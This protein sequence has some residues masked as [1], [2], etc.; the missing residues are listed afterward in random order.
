MDRDYGTHIILGSPGGLG[1]WLESYVRAQ[2]GGDSVPTPLVGTASY[3]AFELLRASTFSRYATRALA[4]PSK[5]RLTRC[6]V[7]GLT[8]SCLAI[9]RTPGL[10]GI[11]RAF[12]MRSSISGAIRGRPSRFCPA[13]G[14]LKPG[15]DSLVNNG[16][17]E[18]GEHAHHLKHRL[19]CRCPGV[20]ALLVETPRFEAGWSE[21]DRGRAPKTGR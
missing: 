11:A 8:A 4:P 2:V 3:P 9:T 5:G 20:E 12:L 18:L 10:P 6:T 14:A 13:L 7:P 15:T 16:A 21:R 19:A 17:L 1:P